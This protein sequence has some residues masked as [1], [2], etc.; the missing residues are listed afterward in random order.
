MGLGKYF[1]KRTFSKT[2][3]PNGTKHAAGGKK[4]AF[5]VQEHHASQLHYDFRLEMDGVL[6]SWA[7]PKGPSL[8]PHDHHLAVQTEDHP[9]EY[10]KF[11]G[12]I[13]EGNY[14][15]G[16]VIIWD[17][18]WYE[19]RK[20][21]LNEGEKTLLKELKKGHITFVLHG[22]KLKGEFALIK[23]QHASDQDAW[24]LVKKDDEFATTTDVKTQDESVK[25]HKKV[26]DL[27]GKMPDI[28]HT[29]KR[30]K[31]WQ[32]KPMLCTLVDDPFSKEGW[33]FEIKWDGYRAIGAKH[34]SDVELYSRNHID[35]AEK[36]PP[37]FEALHALKHD[38]IAD[39]EIVVVDED[40]KPHFEWLQDWRQSRHGSLQYQI[41]DLLW[42]DGHDLR[43]LPLRERKQILTYILPKSDVLRFS[44]DIETN[45]EGLFAEMQKRGME[46]MVAK[47]A[48]STYQENV[49]GQN[50]LKMKTHLRQEVVIGGYTEPRGTRQ[51]LGALIVG[52]YDH[53][54]FVYVGHSG[55]GIAD[56]QRKK[57]RGRLAKIERKSSPFEVEPKPNAPVHWVR[58][59]LVCEMSFSEWTKEGYMRQP[60]YEG[61]RPDKKPQDVH[62]ERAAK[63]MGVLSA[64][65]P[66]QNSRTSAHSAGMPQQLPPHSVGANQSGVTSGGAAP[67]RPQLARTKMGRTARQDPHPSL[68]DLPFEPTHLDKIFFPKHKY[69][70]GDIFNYY[71]SVAEFMLPY[72]KD[73]PCSL[74]RMP[75]GINGES[76]FQKNNEHLPDWVP[77]ADIFSDSNNGNLR[78]IVGKDLNTL[79]YMVQLGC[80]EINPWNSRVGHLENPDWIVIDLDPEGISF[81][82]VIEVARTV[83]EVCDE[84]SIPA[85]PKTSGKTGIHIF[86]PLHAKY[87]YEQ[88]KNLAHLIALEVNKHQ[89]KI[90]SVER[91]PEKRRH[92]IYL[93]F[94]QNREGQ[95]LAAP[96]SLRPTPD[97]TV[98]MPLHWDEVKTGLKPTDFTIENALKRLKRTGDLWKPILDKGID[99][100]KILKGIDQTSN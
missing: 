3:E 4:L 17:E 61:L 15:A 58:P 10:R 24:L 37:V 94:L 23:M 67:L 31:P 6:K 100:A 30:T 8:N 90:T 79:L 44:D 26:D 47:R 7:V 32:V 20:G 92:K 64:A 73:R 49:R 1:R 50:W 45:G 70:K 12:V 43:G 63:R 16:N 81:E 97:A 52:V 62:R 36:Y 69:T 21:D 96:Y 60:K 39:G 59:E 93:D 85:V 83:H 22:K 80:V 5:V 42:C 25:S 27:G 53:G 56:A 48:D 65:S 89:P 86:I 78:W 2:P 77:Y 35:F 51:Y 66:H 55:G 76:F 28:S 34:G 40:G 82:H 72:L 41:F 18:G 98:A 19:A 87:T 11:E 38:I 13:P 74:N 54:A 99:L 71:T 95:T 68:P 29:P 14:G 57:L 46:G 75:G 91:M 9:F 84:W 33:L 88:G